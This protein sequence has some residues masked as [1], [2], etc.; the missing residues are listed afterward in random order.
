LGNIVLPAGAT[1]AM[2]SL[3]RLVILLT[4]EWSLNYFMEKY[5]KIKL[6]DVPFKEEVLEISK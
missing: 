2:D 5:P 6:G 1:L 3:E 4:S